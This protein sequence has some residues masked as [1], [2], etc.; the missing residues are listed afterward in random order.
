L[1]PERR[2]VLRGIAATLAVTGSGGLARKASAVPAIPAMAVKGPEF[3]GFPPSAG[4]LARP[5]TYSLNP[6]FSIVQVGMT[7][8]KFRS[9]YPKSFSLNYPSATPSSYTYGLSADGAKAYSFGQWFQS[10]VTLQYPNSAGDAYDVWN[11]ITNVMGVVQ[12]NGTITGGTS[13]E[14]TP[15][16]QLTKVVLD[17]L[18]A[19][20]S[21]PQ[22]SWLQFVVSSAPTPVHTITI[23]PIPSSITPPIPAGGQTVTVTCPPDNAK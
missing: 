17:C 21:G 9:Q 14:N 13:P 15:L 23:T 22:I 10:L 3:S 1:T 4:P 8:T 11:E 7:R 20:T 2:K 18:A 12:P 6:L 16:Y 5:G 19:P